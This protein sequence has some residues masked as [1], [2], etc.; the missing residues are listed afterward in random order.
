M[1]EHPVL[2]QVTLGYSPMIDRQRAVVVTRLT[3]FPERPDTPP[4]ANALLQALLDVWPANDPP[5]PLTLTLRPLDPKPRG[6]PPPAVKNAP[7]SLNIAGEALLRA[8]MN[9]A[10]PPHLM[11][12]IPSF[13]AA[14]PSCADAILSLRA[15]GSVLLIKGRPLRVLAPEV[16]ACFSHSIVDAGDDRRTDAPA[17][18]GVERNVSTVQAGTH[19]TADVERAFQRGAVAVLGWPYDDPAPASGSRVNL[20]SDVSVVIDLINGVEREEPVAKLEVVLRRD[21]TVAFRLM[22]YLNSPAFGLSVEI[23]SFGHAMMLLG[24][25]RLK[26]WLALL[27]AS[28]SK[29]GFAQ[30]LI[31]A[32]VRRGL[33]LE[34]LGRAQ[35]D[36][37]MR[38][39]MFICGVFSLLDKL[40]Q[41]PFAG[42]MQNVPVPE[43][44]QQALRGEGGPYQP[45]LE[46]LRAIE[47]EAVFDIRDCSDRLVLGPTEVNRALLM[48]LSSARQ[49][50]G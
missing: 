31:H 10:P 4:D 18:P 14:D 25:S 47:Q 37:E 13:M 17:P 32:A 11:L 49:L 2:G 33:L 38:G 16:L 6:T 34:E 27:L 21:P 50:D 36:A 35:G 3:I 20:A 41:Q 24:H 30:P 48:A 12:E 9:A 8:V 7:V 15:A 44:V 5:N 29:A 22:R 40:L 45:Y 23:N 43:R 39:E 28:S 42:L 19:S 46:L 26:R 1:Q